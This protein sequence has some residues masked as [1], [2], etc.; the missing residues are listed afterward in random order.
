M[1]YLYT[2]ME[3]QNN[4]LDIRGL[5]DKAASIIQ[6][7]AQDLISMLQDNCDAIAITG[8]VLTKDFVDGLSDINS[9]LVLKE[10]KIPVLDSLASMGSRY[11]KKGVRAPL[12]MTGDYIAR[13]LDVFPIEFLD[14]KLLHKTIYGNDVFSDIAIEKPMLRLQCESALKAK[15]IHLRQGFIVASGKKNALSQLLFDAY[16]GFFPLFRAILYLEQG[17][18]GPPI[19]KAEVLKGMEKTFSIPMDC[20]K[21]IQ[22]LRTK[23]R[24]S[25]PTEQAH[26][27]FDEV[28]KITHELSAK[29]DEIAI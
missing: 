1:L 14:I 10:M 19:L 27:L 7:F 2:K 6:E 23:K 22:G 15:L 17:V 3:K 21:E 11:G 9:V 4:K 29:V 8:S 5:P 18:E 24:P 26:R 16:P 13:S 25:V 12:I 28:Y 20:L